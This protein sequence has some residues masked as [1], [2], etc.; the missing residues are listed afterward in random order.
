MF[1]AGHGLEVMGCPSCSLS[2]MGQADDAVQGLYPVLNHA[3]VPF[4]GPTRYLRNVETL[5]QALAYAAGGF[6]V[7]VTRGLS[8][9]CRDPSDGFM[10]ARG[11]FTGE[12]LTPCA[13]PLGRDDIRALWAQAAQGYLDA[14]NLGL[15]T[16]SVSK[17]KA[18]LRLVQQMQVSPYTL[19][20]V[21]P[22]RDPGLDQGSS[23]PE[24]AH[25]PPVLAQP[26]KGL[27]GGAVVAAGAGLMALTGLVVGVLGAAR[28]KAQ[29]V[30]V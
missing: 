19:E 17:V 26:R 2:V 6:H 24:P 16:K 13:V 7:S 1:L 15:R 28:K 18:A 8:G 23:L 9:G 29:R 20:N 3:L 22:P 11:L 27:G 30:G 14:Y 12:M 21:D 5:A 25:E 10:E 4:L